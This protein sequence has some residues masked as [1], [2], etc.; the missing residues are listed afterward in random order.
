MLA[1]LRERHPRVIAPCAVRARRPR[2]SD[3]FGGGDGDDAHVAR[4]RFLVR[5][6]VQG[7]GFRAHAR[8][9]A[10]RL[11]LVGFVANRADGAVEGEADGD[12][13]ALAGFRSWLHR[14]PT[15][16]RVDAV[17]WQPAPAVAREASFEV[18]R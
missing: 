9:E 3:D 5:G 10:Q 8:G 18:R 1:C 7:V 13:A 2:R 15:W 4:F 14:G 11:G 17:D 6:R 16:A 12:D